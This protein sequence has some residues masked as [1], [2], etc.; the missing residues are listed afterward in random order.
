MKF[1]RLYSEIKRQYE[2]SPDAQE[3]FSLRTLVSEIWLKYGYESAQHILTP[4]RE[5]EYS[6]KIIDD[7]KRAING[8]PLQYIAGKTQFWNCEFYVGEGILIPRS[9]TEISVEKALER[10]ND[11]GIVYDICC[12]SGCIGISLLKNSTLKKCYSFD[13]S[14]YAL[15]YTKRNGYLNGVEDRLEVLK[16]D[17]MSALPPRELPASDLIISNPPYITTEEM[18][19]LPE[20][21]R[22]EPSIA[23]EGGNDGADFYRRIIE[24]FTPLLRDGGYMIFEI[25]PTQS[26]ILKEL[27]EKHG[28]EYEFFADYRGNVRTACGKKEKNY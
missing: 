15:E 7:A 3:Y 27:F 11:G 18:K 14:P 21:V 20:N 1:T 22:F 13:I 6:D 9:D 2:A 23:L 24:D 12:G 19:N 16:Y 17:V 5:A 26:E 10:I 8:Y 4:D 28:Y 25:A